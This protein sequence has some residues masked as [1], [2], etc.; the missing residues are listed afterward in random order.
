MKK[1]LLISGVLITLLLVLGV[2]G[3][4]FMGISV[5]DP[6]PILR[7]GTAL[8]A[9]L[10]CS[11]HHLTGMPEKAASEEI[12]S[13]VPLG[14]WL[15]VDYR[16]DN[17]LV[18]A[19]LMRTST[20]TATYRPGLGCTINNGDTSAVDALVVAPLPAEVTAPWPAGNMVDSIN[21]GM[22][23]LADSILQRDNAA[24]Y[25]TRAIA[26][27]HQ[28]KLVAEA[29]ADGF[30]S[31]SQLMGWS[32]GKSLTSTMLGHLAYRGQLDVNENNLFAD[33]QNDQRATITLQ[34][35]LQMTSGLDFNEA[36]VAGSDATRML[37][38][39]NSS[40]AVAL[41]S[42]AAHMPGQHFA[43]SSGTTNALM[44]WLS[45]RLGG[46][47]AL[48]DFLVQRIYQPLHLHHTTFEV[49]PSGL[50]VGSSY[51]YAS[52]RDWARMGQLWLNR[53]TLN[54]SRLLSEA[55]VD[56]ATQ[57]NPSEN[58]QA[59][60]Y[61]FWLNRGNGDLRWPELPADTYAM[62]GN[63]QQSVAIIPSRQVVLVRLGWT[64]GRYPMTTNYRTLLDGL[65]GH[66]GLD[67]PADV[68]N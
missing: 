57:P 66:A 30:N 46:H 52:A 28:G 68:A 1:L 9:K 24:G 35:M 20:K 7:T 12:Y 26:V 49:D 50:P 38:T 3:L 33:W 59:Y 4:R 6:G 53:G 45:N 37:F 60:G 61:Q 41:A 18:A 13:Y 43:Y 36:Y 15:R 62:T 39:A 47:Q 42:P 8:A 48:L 27:V 54:G 2:I 63:R 51:L 67:S 5:T 11:A 34:N 25:N 65:A 21:P 16:R 56:A 40:A 17:R 58:F 22:Q 55:W 14:D 64:A 44:Q 23:T 31:E 19:T 10:A 32:M 29:Y